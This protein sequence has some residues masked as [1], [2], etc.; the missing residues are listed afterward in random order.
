MSVWTHIAAIIRVDSIGHIVGVPDGTVETGIRSIVKQSPIPSG[1]EG[2]AKWDFVRVH[3]E[4][5]PLFGN[6]ILYGDLRDYDDAVEI[7]EWML[8][9][10]RTMEQGG[11]GIRG[12]AGSIEVEQQGMYAMYMTRQPDNT[13]VLKSQWFEAT[14]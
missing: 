1:T 5:S 9:L 2:P 8:Y 13:P 7:Q 3:S 4:Y 10:I 14:E 11:L 6:V 12:F